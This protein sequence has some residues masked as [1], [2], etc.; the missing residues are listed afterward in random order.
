MDRK[1]YQ[2]RYRKENKDKFKIY[3][4]RYNRNNGCIPLDEWYAK[5][6]KPLDEWTCVH[7]LDPKERARK[8][9]NR[10]C[11]KGRISKPTSCSICNKTARIYGH[12]ENYEKWQE[13]IWCCHNCHLDIHNNNWRRNWRIKNVI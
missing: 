10:A 2:K 4:T 5:V 6:T 9:L 1:E 7:E 3:R 11:R 8:L 12:H 13:V